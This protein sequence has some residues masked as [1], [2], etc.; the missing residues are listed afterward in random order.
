MKAPFSID[1]ESPDV[2]SITPV[3]YMKCA[4]DWGRK[5]VKRLKKAKIRNHRYFELAKS[6]KTHIYYDILVHQV[7]FVYQD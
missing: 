7:Y 6:G 2:F 4:K 5:F 1:P 3:E